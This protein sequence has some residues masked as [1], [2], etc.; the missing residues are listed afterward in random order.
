VISIACVN[1]S[2]QTTLSQA[3][4][5][6]QLVKAENAL[7]DSHE[8]KRPGFDPTTTTQAVPAKSP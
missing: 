1:Q 5:N 7:P 4:D 6:G 3:F 2:R 8:Q